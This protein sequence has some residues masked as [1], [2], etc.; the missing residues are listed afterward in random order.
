MAELIRTVQEFKMKLAHCATILIGT[1]SIGGGLA[2]AQDPWDPQG[3]GTHLQA[4]GFVSIRVDSANN[5]NWSLTAVDG[6]L[7][8]AGDPNF[9]GALVATK[10][11]GPETL[12]VKIKAKHPHE[13]PY[14]GTSPAKYEYEIEY[15]SHRLCKGKNRA[16][17]IPGS[18]W[19]TT[20]PVYG[21][22]TGKMVSFAC[23]P[24]KKVASGHVVFTGGG[25][26]AKCVDWGYPPWVLSNAAWDGPTFGGFA[27]DATNGFQAI[28]MHLACLSMAMADYCADGNPHTVDGTWIAFGSAATLSKAPLTQTPK[29]NE[30]LPGEMT[31]KHPKHPFFFEAAWRGD[32]YGP[33]CVTKT[34]WSTIPLELSPTCP[35]IQLPLNPERLFCENFSEQE[36]EGGNGQPTL[37]TYSPFLDVGLYRCHKGATGGA[38]AWVTTGTA[39]LNIPSLNPKPPVHYQFKDDAAFA[40]DDQDFEGTVLRPDA[41]SALLPNGFP[42]WKG[43]AKK[44]PVKLYLHSQSGKY[45]TD[46]N[47]KGSPPP[48]HIGYILTKDFCRGGSGPF[49]GAAL[50]L[51][52]KSGPPDEYWTSTKTP[53]P[54]GFSDQGVLGYMIKLRP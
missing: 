13:N 25:V 54:P 50:K 35:L 27:L 3:Q 32:P 16:L 40:C 47:K 31:P 42:D 29:P 5:N 33:I 51:Y 26:A 6:V 21:H 1:L 17:A 41:T 37:F 15:G 45:I 19:P 7:T 48:R 11:G 38:T 10:N 20:V 52:K 44:R 18:Y 14:G 8:V 28:Q 22:D 46:T 30:K 24:E 12:D 23:I 36:L 53:P 9:T 4:E 2:Q 43:P 34:R 49:C 39:D